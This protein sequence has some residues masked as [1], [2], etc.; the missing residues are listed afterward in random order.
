MKALLLNSPFLDW[1]FNG[2]MRKVAIPAFGALGRLFPDLAISQGD[3]TGYQESLLK[4]IM[5]NGTTIRTGNCFIR[6][7]LTHHGPGL[8]APHRN[9]IK[10][11]AGI[12]V[13]ILLMHSDKSVDGDHWTPEFQHADAVLNV[14]DISRIGRK[15]G[16]DVTED[17]IRGRAARPCALIAA[18]ERASLQLYLQLAPP[19]TH[20]L[21]S[22]CDR[23]EKNG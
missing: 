7:K 6:R 22:V 9:K 8:S 11:G 18:G 16:Q 23:S 10:K 20:F 14:K 12:R 5:A 21:I 4:S 2:F 13:P 19:K 3:G 15:L 1:N 17:T